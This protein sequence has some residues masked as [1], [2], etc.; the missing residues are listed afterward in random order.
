VIV[1]RGHDAAMS[2]VVFVVLNQHVHEVPLADDQHAIQA[3]A[4][5]GVDPSLG[6]GNLTAW[7]VLTGNAVPC[8]SYPPARG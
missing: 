7:D 2:I 3:F 4:A 5:D 6:V 1:A 8:S